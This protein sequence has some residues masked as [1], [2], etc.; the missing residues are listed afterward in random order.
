MVDF[1]FY[2]PTKI[3]FGKGREKEVGEILK[4]RNVQKVLFHYGQSSIKK[5]GLYDVIIK[6]LQDAKVSFV[7]LVG[8]EPNPKVE[9]VRKG[10]EIAKNEKIDY[11]LACGGGSVI[12]S[13]KAIACGFYIDED[14]WKLSTHEVIPH[15]ALPVGVITTHSASGSEM[16]NSCVIS[17]LSEHEKRGF[18]T[19]IIRPQFCIM[20]PT[21]TY[22]LSSF[23]TACGVV[24]ILMH[25]MERYFTDTTDA[26]FSDAMALAL[27][28]CV[29]DASKVLKTNPMDYQARST[30]M[31]A[32][33]FSHNGLTGLGEKMYF[34][35]HKIEHLLSG[36]KDSITHAAGLSVI[37]PAWARFVIRHHAYPVNKDKFRI[38]AKEIFKIDNSEK[39]INQ[40]VEFFK[41]LNMPLT[42]KEI[43]IYPKD[44]NKIINIATRDFTHNI[45]GLIPINR[46]ALMEILELAK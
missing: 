43:G 46:L 14:C 13:A 6:S 7:E 26:G 44:F 35:V 37:F 10:I 2:S 20:D 3:Y 32:S 29:M 16:S 1:D 24:D 31:L 4:A 36:E 17:N 33:S 22:S 21:L 11:I 18:N 42:L 9:L 30:L 5:N 34:T 39:G 40:L 12:D 25:T 27:I 23:Q 15:K 19:D 38:F 41:D 8:V 28:K 45:P